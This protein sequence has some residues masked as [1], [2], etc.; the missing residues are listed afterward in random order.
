MYWFICRICQSKTIVK[1]IVM[2]KEYAKRAYMECP[3]C[4]RSWVVGIPV[5]WEKK[6]V[7]EFAEKEYQDML[8]R[9]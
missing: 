8:S 4:G 6:N 9:N 2:K 7:E 5:N 3:T 1:K